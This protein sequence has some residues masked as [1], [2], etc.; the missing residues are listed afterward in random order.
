TNR[1]DVLDPALLRPGRFDRHITIDRPTKAGRLG[2]LKVHS[3]KVPLADDVDLEEIAAATIGFSG[4]EL[5]NLVNEAALN[6]ARSSQ[7][8]VTRD[9]FDYARDRVLMGPRREEVLNKHEREMTAYHEAGHALLGW[10][11]P[12]A[13]PVHKVTIIPRGRALGVTQFLPD[14]DRYSIGER[15]L[16]TQLIVALGG[17][18]AE[19]LVF[20]EFT[21]GGE[22]DLKQVTQ[23]ARRMVAN[24][25]MSEVIG[26]VAFTQVEDHPFL[27]KEIHEQRTY[28]DETARLID[29]EIQRFLVGAAENAMSILKK[30]RDQLDSLASALQEHE[31]VDSKMLEELIGKAGQYNLQE[32]NGKP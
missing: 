5:K 32:T 23:I 20:D 9:D 14:D 7:T 28:S 24:W 2:I 16:Q 13:D 18:A 22:G 31:S 19:K 21:A 3:R 15:R 17:R 6:A 27:G 29:Q 12:E 8:S 30:H 1:P 26:P 11:L 25:G 10:L 4:A